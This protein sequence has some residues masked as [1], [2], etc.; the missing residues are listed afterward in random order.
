[1]QSLCVIMS[2]RRLGHSVSETV[3]WGRG[4]EGKE[5]GRG[6]GTVRSMMLCSLQQGLLAVREVAHKL[7]VLLQWSAYN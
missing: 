1:M 7:M 6:R 4:G 2:R 5:R 3:P